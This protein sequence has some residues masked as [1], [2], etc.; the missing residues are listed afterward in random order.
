MD[1]IEEFDEFCRVR[2]R[3]GVKGAQ[4]HQP[5]HSGEGRNPGD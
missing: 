5:R 3:T 1:M 4:A 2:L